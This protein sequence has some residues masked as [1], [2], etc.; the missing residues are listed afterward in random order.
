MEQDGEIVVAFGDGIVKA[1]YGAY[2]AVAGDSADAVLTVLEVDDPRPFGVTVLDD[3]GYV[4]RF[5]EKPETFEHKLVAT[6][7]NW[8]RSSRQLLDAIDT[9]VRDNRQTKGE[10]Y[11]AD[12]Y[13]VL[14]ERGAKIKTM[15]VDY[16]LDA[17]NPKTILATNARMMGLGHGTHDAIERGYG[18]G[19]TVIPPVWI[20]E[21]AEIEASVIGPYVHID[22][23]VV[24]RRAVLSNTIV[25]PGA[26]LE[27]CVLN[28]ALVG[29]NATVKGKPSKLFI[30][31][32]A[33]I[34]PD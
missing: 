1:N 23:N 2:H 31:D 6:G 34:K 12:A 26:K 9:I 15:T 18:E 21:S 28:H 20:A 27:N 4:T 30:G 8:F 13:A 33:Y 7:I 25:D 3:D 10:F 19:F 5:V 11:M 22:E 32:N 24:V 29:E 14:L 17:G 16:W